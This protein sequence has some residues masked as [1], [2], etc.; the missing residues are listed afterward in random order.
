LAIGVNRAGN[1][2]SRRIWVTQIRSNNLNLNTISSQF[3]TQLLSPYHAVC[4]RNQEAAARTSQAP[5]NSLT[6]SGAP[7]GYDRHT[8]FKSRHVCHL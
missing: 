7:T 5:N 3:V 4:S 6:N 2:G 8:T 1:D